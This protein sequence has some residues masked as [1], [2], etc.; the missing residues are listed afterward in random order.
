MEPVIAVKLRLKI[1]KRNSYV[2]NGNGRDK[3]ESKRWWTVENKR[4]MKRREGSK[5][6]LEGGWMVR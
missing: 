5:R 3:Y 6:G 1:P 2:I 4:L